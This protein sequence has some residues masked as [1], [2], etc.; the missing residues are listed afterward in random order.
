MLRLAGVA[1]R[2]TQG[3]QNPPGREVRVG[4]NPTSGTSVHAPK[5]VATMRNSTRTTLLGVGLALVAFPAFAGCPDGMR[6]FRGAISEIG[7]R[8]LFVDSR[9]EDNIGFE[10]AADTRVIGRAGWDALKAGDKVAICWR[11]EDRPRKAVS[12]TVK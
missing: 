6:E 7:P 4:S 1:E 8:K 10:R 3:T 5:M 12:V 11:F 2:Q 9:L